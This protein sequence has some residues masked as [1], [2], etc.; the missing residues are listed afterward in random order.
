MIIMVNN[1]PNDFLL[2]YSWHKD[3]TNFMKV[4]S[5]LAKQIYDLIE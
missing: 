1:W 4:E 2:N 3:L 5:L